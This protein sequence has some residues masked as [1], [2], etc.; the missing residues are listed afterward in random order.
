MGE[1]IF[2]FLQNKM[3]TPI[4]SPDNYS[5]KMSNPNVKMDSIPQLRSL[6]DQVPFYVGGSNAV[7]LA[8]KKLGVNA[9]SAKEMAHA[10]KRK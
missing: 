6:G 5:F 3:Q 4:A 10:G 9:Y 7:P 1:I 2:L 8:M